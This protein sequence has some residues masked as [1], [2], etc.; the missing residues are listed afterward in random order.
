MKIRD[1]RLKSG[2]TQQKM[3]ELFEIPKRTIENWEAETRKCPGYVEKL[4]IEKLEGIVI[5]N[6]KDA[7]KKAKEINKFQSYIPELE[8][9]EIV[10]LNDLWDGEG[11][12][13]ETSYSYILTDTGEDDNSNYEVWINYEFEIIEKKDNDLDTL[14]KITNISLI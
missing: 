8:I 5:M 6:G 11:D 13:P 7:L 9:G 2:L 3:S 4:I 10:E 14:V 1:Y 12:V